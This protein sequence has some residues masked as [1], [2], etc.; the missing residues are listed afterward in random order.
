MFLL[1]FFMSHIFCCVIK[2]LLII[3]GGWSQPTSVWDLDPKTTITNT[4]LEMQVEKARKVS[5]GWSRKTTFLRMFYIKFYLAD[6][7]S[8]LRMVHVQL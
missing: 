3:S 4:E 2:M 6:H 5:S 1:P 7:I 8:K